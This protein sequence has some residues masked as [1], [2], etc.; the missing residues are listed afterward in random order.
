MHILLYVPNN[1]ANGNFVPQ[2]WPFLLRAQTPPEHQV[3]ILDSNAVPCTEE[4]LIQFI[5]EKNVKLV[6]M[7]FMTRMARKA[8][9]T[10]A[11]IRGQTGVPV[12]M[13]GPHVTELP[14]EPLGR[15]GQP[16]CAD[17]VVLG[18][19]D[20]IWPQV[21]HDAACGQLKDVYG[22]KPAESRSTKPSLAEYPVIAWDQMDLSNF[23]LM[24]FV[25]AS[26]RKV[27]SKIGIRYERVFV[28]PVES[29][30]GCPYGC[31]F[32][33]VT[34][35]FGDDVRFRSNASV[36]AELKSLK[37]LAER[38]KALVSVF[39]VDDN[40]AIRRER[41]KSLLRNMIANDVCL[42]WV[43]QISVNLLKDEELVRL[44]RASGGRFVFVGLES[45]DRKSLASAKKGFNKPEEYAS[46]LEMLSRFDIYAITSFIM[47]M[48]EDQPGVSARITS[49]L[50]V[51]PPGLPVFGLLTPYPGTP[52]YK[53]LAGEKRL[54]RPDHWND[55]RPFKMA[56]QPR[57]IT[58][59]EAEQEVL[60]SW[61]QS[62]GTE[63]FARTQSWLLAHRKPFNYQVMLFVA[64]LLF[65]GI[66]FPQSTRQAWLWLLARNF[67]TITSMIRHRK[68]NKNQRTLDAVW[69]SAGK[70]DNSPNSAIWNKEQQHP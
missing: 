54:V 34:G 20:D 70:A 53:R 11:A 56:F 28:I 52:L 19:A 9:F 66:Y 6:G 26:V 5:R 21:V 7:G 1:H 49:E 59:D 60:Q 50:A 36:I 57:N 2:L 35:F 14:D 33:T 39:F 13:G 61:Q 18:E 45:I 63:A 25:P 65:R 12:V 67:R 38:E 43:A 27:F 16:K 42:P 30:R 68:M 22:A 8:Y 4:S 24:R 29:G 62:Y 10:A 51:W 47:G 46:V 64:R 55:F 44:I 69:E 41:L 15:N 40:L 37:R 23:D 48:D 3:T 17:A 32:C 58:A 31:E